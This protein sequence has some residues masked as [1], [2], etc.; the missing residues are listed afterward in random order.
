MT[1]KTFRR[2]R[3]DNDLRQAELAML[4]RIGSS[5]TISRYERGTRKICGPVSLLM[6][7]LDMYGGGY[8]ATWQQVL[9]EIEK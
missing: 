5:E 3:K 8:L 1:P 7:H 2:I 4:L 6:D 9:R